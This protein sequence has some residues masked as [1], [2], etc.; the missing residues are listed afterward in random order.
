MSEIEVRA[1]YIEDLPFIFATLLRS[2]RHA[3][4]FARKISNEVFYKY[5]HMFLDQCLKRPESKVMVAHPKNDPNVILGYILSETR[6]DGEEV[7]HYTYVKKSFREMGVARALWA[8]LD[9]DKKYVITHY[10]MDAD[11][12]VKKF[13]LKYNPYLL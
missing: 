8:T 2:Y 4:T 10:T 13:N 12:I 11:W 7:V 6:A 5:H 9:K 1:A 3:S